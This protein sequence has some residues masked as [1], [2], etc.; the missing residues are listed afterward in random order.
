MAIKLTKMAVI[1]NRKCQNVLN[2]SIKTLMAHLL[3]KNYQEIIKAS[4]D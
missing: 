2:L 4:R 1:H 3:T